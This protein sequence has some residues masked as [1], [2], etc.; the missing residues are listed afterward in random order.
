LDINKN[1][2]VIWTGFYAPPK[3]N[4]VDDCLVVGLSYGNANWYIFLQ[5]YKN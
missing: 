3:A 4:M 5:K 1:K 2:I